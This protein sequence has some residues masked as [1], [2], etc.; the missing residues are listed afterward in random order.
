MFICWDW[1]VI[2][3]EFWTARDSPHP[4]PQMALD[5]P[6]VDEKIINH[7]ILKINDKARIVLTSE[8]SNVGRINVPVS[9]HDLGESL[10][11][12]LVGIEPT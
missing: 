3:A 12:T 4:L 1:Q 9:S 8:R 7:I 6:Q 5:Y 10:S 11:R 2:A